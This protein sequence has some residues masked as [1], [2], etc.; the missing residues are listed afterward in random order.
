[1]T[2]RGRQRRAPRAFVEDGR[3]DALFDAGVDGDE[4]E[5]QK[6][7]RCSKASIRC[8]RIVTT[9]QKITFMYAGRAFAF[10]DQSMA[11]WMDPD[12]STH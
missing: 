6:P 5:G 11:P 3:V 2:R 4:G 8:H 7:H 1:V 10:V 12:W 9:Q